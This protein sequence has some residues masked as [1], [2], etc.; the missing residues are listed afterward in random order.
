MPRSAATTNAKPGPTR[1]AAKRVRRAGEQAKTA[2]QLARAVLAGEL[3]SCPW[4]AL[5]ALYFKG[6]TEEACAAKLARWAQ[7]HGI[8]L[9]VERH[10]VIAL[11]REIASYTVRF[12]R[13]AG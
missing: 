7:K 8:G 11:G 6:R 4:A 5:K 3:R 12:K 9:E 2:A 13:P 10:R 1:R